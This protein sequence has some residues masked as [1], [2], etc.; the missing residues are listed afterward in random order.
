M[1]RIGVWKI[2]PEPSQGQAEGK[3]YKKASYFIHKR[4]VI[5]PFEFAF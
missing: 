1:N 2:W 3:I 4:M 5:L